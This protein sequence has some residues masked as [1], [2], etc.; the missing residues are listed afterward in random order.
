MLNP[1]FKFHWLRPP[2]YWTML[3]DTKL[4]VFKT[5]CGVHSSNIF[6]KFVSSYL[7]ER[8]VKTFFN[9]TTSES[10]S[11]TSIVKKH[12]E[13]ATLF[14]VGGFNQSERYQSTAIIIPG[15]MEH[16]TYF[17]QPT[18]F[19][20]NYT[21]SWFFQDKQSKVQVW[22]KIGMAKPQNKCQHLWLPNH[23]SSGPDLLLHQLH[24]TVASWPQISSDASPK[25][26]GFIPFFLLKPPC[27]TIVAA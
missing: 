8:K 23:K 26:I 15:R 16:Q 24:L 9:T 19:D 3:L 5:K 1:I 6:C 17:K 25:S 27:F 4:V 20:R 18:S 12:D 21:D 7:L 11:F 14:L 10:D 2:I 13:I 22:S